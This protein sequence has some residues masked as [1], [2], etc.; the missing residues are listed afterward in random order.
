M[1]N[2][3][4]LWFY[5]NDGEFSYLIGTYEYPEYA[6]RHVQARTDVAGWNFDGDNWS[7]IDD[8]VFDSG[9][10]GKYLIVREV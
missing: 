3:F 8:I 6:F 4:E 1:T 9:H 10:T 2:D 5:G 7:T